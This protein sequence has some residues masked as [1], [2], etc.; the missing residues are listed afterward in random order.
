MQQEDLTIRR[1]KRYNHV[2][3]NLRIQIGSEWRRIK[4]N[5]WNEVGFN[6]YLDF[7]LQD[8]KALFSKGASH[9]PG[10]IVWRY[11]NEDD[12]IVL[13][14]ILNRLLTEHIRKAVK[15]K[16]SIRRVLA[17]MR[18]KGRVDEKMSV[19]SLLGMSMSDEDKALLIRNSKEEYP[20]YRYGVKVEAKKWID[21]VEATLEA[22]SV[23]EVLAQMRADLDHIKSS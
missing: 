19:L 8:S 2:A 5:D 14:M 22:T 10:E 11:K 9:F 4:A 21:V 20:F 18:E 1:K 12:S 23:L 7:H 6:F 13:E 3:I 15:D 16:A 17:L